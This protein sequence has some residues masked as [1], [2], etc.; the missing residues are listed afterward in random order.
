M[1][2]FVVEVADRYGCP[3][4]RCT[5]GLGRYRQDGLPGL[6]DTSYQ[7]HHH[8]GHFVSHPVIRGSAPSEVFRASEQ[9]TYNANGRPSLANTSAPRAIIRSL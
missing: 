6:A 1:S 3:A 9:G 7:T 4:R 8:P 5:R 2:D